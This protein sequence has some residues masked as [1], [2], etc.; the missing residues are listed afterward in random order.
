MYAH[1]AAEYMDVLGV[2]T[3]GFGRPPEIA[4][5]GEICPRDNPMRSPYA[6]VEGPAIDRGCWPVEGLC[7]RRVEQMRAIM[8]EHGD[9]DTPMWA[10]EFGWPIRPRPCC[11]ARSEWPAQSWQA[12]SEG[13]QARYLIRA[14]RYAEEQ[15]PWMEVMF[16]WNL[17][18]S[19]YQE[20][21][22]RCGYCEPMGAY[23]I[24]DPDGTPRL[25]YKWLIGEDVRH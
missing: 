2:H 18:W 21:E 19:R 23:S 16:L 22:E 9:E 6:R 13:Q 14:Y 20:E 15:W 12:V 17:D 11:L 24:L 8:V 7:F 1:G 4:P 10:T 25:A 3:F 5:D